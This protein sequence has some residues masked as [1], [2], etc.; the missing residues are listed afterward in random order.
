[1]NPHSDTIDD[2]DDWGNHCS[3]RED[4]RVRDQTTSL[5]LSIQE[6]HH[7][8]PASLS[9]SKKSIYFEMPPQLHPACSL[10]V[11]RVSSC[12]FSLASSND[13]QSMTD[14]LSQPGDNGHGAL[15]K[16]ENKNE[17]EENE[18]HPIDNSVDVF[19]HDILMQV[20]TFLDPSS[21]LC[22]SETARRPNFEVFYFLQLQLQQALLLDKDIKNCNVDNIN[23]MSDRM[24]NYSVLTIEGSASLLS[25]AARSDM[26]KARELVEEYQDSNST[27]RTMPLSYSLAYVRHYL[28]RN[29]FHKMFSNTVN[30]DDTN[31][32][33]RSGEI[34]SSK[35]S[36]SQTL[37]SAAI[38]VTVVGAASLVST[39]D[40]PITM[41]TDHFGTE[42]PNVLFRVGFV[43][44]LMRAISDTERGTAMR[45]KAEQMA[46]SMQELPAALMPKRRKYERQEQPQLQED[47][48]QSLSSSLK[49]E[50]SNEVGSQESQPSSHFQ[51][52]MNF[53]LPSLYEMRHMLQEMV[54]SNIATAK[55]EK[56]QPLLFDP[57]GHLPSQNS[58]ND[59]SSEEDNREEKKGC[60]HD[61]NNKQRTVTELNK[62]MDV[63]KNS[64][65]DR[66]VP[67]GCVGAYSRAIHKA[68]DH[69][70]SQI[71]EKRKLMFESLSF[72]DQR[73]RSLEF[74]SVCASNDT[75]DRVKEMISVMDVNRFYI[76]NDGTETCALHTAAFNGADKVVEF[77]CA[78]IDLQ[79]SRLDG[80]LC[81]VNA[82]DNNG[83]S[84]LHFAA[85][86]NS[87]A[88]VRVLA[89][90]G[91]IL[92]VE[93]HNGYAPLAWAVRLSYEGV[94]EELRELMNKLDTDQSGTW[95]YSKP[96]VSIAAHFFSL[97]PT[98]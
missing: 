14:L 25:R 91:A 71:K 58:T 40:A 1:M 32:C 5:P 67:S 18:N 42:L 4:P 63:T 90:H 39:S 36:S 9:S 75:I 46:R 43:G 76:G 69:V 41:M 2:G 23:R 55:H 86:A 48:T 93:A 84:A 65:A 30:R 35:I 3:P 47:S 28:L 11:R 13:K 81:D 57:Y 64:T 17:V 50:E 66:K 72:E 22:F 68:A 33:N 88:A 27:L 85:G 26:G 56:P 87:V 31:D 37:A 96:L 62:A 52:R 89:H 51:H 15:G 38:F 45:E 49:Q 7:T 97:I 6:Q 79:D 16:S 77:L 94:A 20:F 78:G 8:E 83:W 80:G 10:G 44:S 61:D 59:E 12:Y 54:S 34:Q 98:H 21:L 82:K 60:D 29:G 95:T 19:Y 70:T 73:Q 92:N 24:D 74:L 53:V